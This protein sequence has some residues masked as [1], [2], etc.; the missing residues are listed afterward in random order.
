MIRSF[1]NKSRM[2][3]LSS[4]PKCGSTQI[5]NAILIAGSLA[6]EGWKWNNYDIHTIY[7]SSLQNRHIP[8][9]PPYNPY[10]GSNM[11]HM[12]THFSGKLFIPKRLIYWTHIQKNITI[13]RNPFDT[14]LSTINFIA[15]CVNN[16]HNLSIYDSFFKY[17]LPEIKLNVSKK[18]LIE[19]LTLLNLR[20]GG[21]LDKALRRFSDLDT[22]LPCKFTRFSGKWKDFDESYSDAKIPRLIIKYED[23]NFSKVND[24]F[25][26]IVETICE[27]LETD[28]KILQEALSIQDSSARN[29][30]SGKTRFY[31]KMESYYFK[32]YFN[33][34]SLE[35][36]RT[37]H[38]D[39]LQRMGYENLL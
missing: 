28:R 37:R 19:S 15:H 3:L 21:H 1:K 32:K 33:D 35:Y 7:R 22:A 39:V 10:L 31:N 13:I 25:S 24:Q 5:S 30:D 2:L 36:F 14:L 18:K 16:G 17:I 26:S 34:E 9:L 20:D 12:K 8:K 4:F 38:S 6:S 29:I 11:L 27:F 23:V